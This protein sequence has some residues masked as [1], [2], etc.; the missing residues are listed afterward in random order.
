MKTVQVLLRETVPHVGKVGDVVE[1]RTGFARNYLVPNKLAVDATPANVE[2]MKRRRV[3]YDAEEKKMLAEVEARVVALGKVSV[4]TSSKA[5]ENGHLYGS[6]NAAA[7]ARL[8]G[9]A[10]H[11]TEEKAVRL[12]DP[13]KAVGTHAVEVHVHGERAATIT[14][15]V[16]AAEA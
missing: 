3:L 8:L 16:T 10:G 13:I 1:V 11:A 2:I 5:D 12:A 7:I 14:V 15:V 4:T 9:E 6:V